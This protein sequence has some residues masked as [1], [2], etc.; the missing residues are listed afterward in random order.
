[1]ADSAP[2]S[3]ERA[4]LLEAAAKL[5]PVLEAGTVASE[6]LRRLPEATVA[7]LHASGFFRMLLPR[8]M[9]GLEVDP[10]TQSEVIEQVAQADGSAAWCAFIGASSSGFVAAQLPD[11]GIREVVERAGGAW[12][13]F[14][15]SPATGGTA[16]RVPGGYQ[17]AGRWAWASGIGHAT[18]LQ[19]GFMV[20]ENGEPAH[21][22]N[23]AP[24]MRAAVFPV[25][26]VHVEDSWHTLGLRG[27]GSAH[28]NT[29]G[30]FVPEERTYRFLD[31]T[32]RRGGVLFRQP[33]LGFFGPA[34][35]GFFQGLGRRALDEIA[36]VAQTKT[37][38]MAGSRLAERAVFQ[39]DLALADGRLRAARLLLHHEL[40][41]LWQ[42]LHADRPATDLENN[43]LLFA[44]THNAQTAV[45]A[46]DMAF[47]YGGGEAI[48]L[49]GR[50]QQIKRDVEAGAQH[51][52]VGDQ[53]L[54]LLGKAMLGLGGSRPGLA[55]E[56][57]SQSTST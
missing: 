53:N 56:V 40:D 9:G 12:P 36:R 37:R 49:S 39:R 48:F 23:G 7:A 28:F 44:F 21:D 41:A 17:V 46:A 52:L 18:W 30:I 31:P 20:V 54:E 33:V 50:I 38:V 15:G 47:R 2:R 6:S 55:T 25:A 4:Q 45:E 29:P 32:P 35:S 27:T 8:E 51:I 14:A 16:T 26:D 57:A 5:G 19:A 3:P 1:M 34:F 10:V 11:T 22:E 13:V 42:R 43:R 24:M